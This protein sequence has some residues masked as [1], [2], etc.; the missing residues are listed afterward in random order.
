MTSQ[1]TA[2]HAMEIANGSALE[3]VSAPLIAP[4]KST[5]TQH[6]QRRAS[7]SPSPAPSTA[8]HAIQ[9]LA[10]PGAA[11][12][13]PFSMHLEVQREAGAASSERIHEAAGRGMATPTT[14]MPYA[15]AIAASFG[16]GHDLSGLQAHVGGDASTACRDMNALAFASGNHV[17]FAGAPSLHTAAHEAAHVIQQR[18]GV[19]LK[20]GVGEVGDFYERNADEVADRVVAGLPA[21]DLL[22]APTSSGGGGVQHQAIQRYT[23]VSDL[24][25]D[26]VSDDGKLAVIDHGLVGWAEDSMIAAANAA[27]TAN[28]SKI[29]VEALG[30]GDADVAPPN[31]T[32]GAST[33]RLKQFHM[34]D[35]TTSD[36]LVLPDDC[37]GATQ[38]AL[39]SEHHGRESFVAAHKQGTTE[40]YT[41]EE[42]YHADDLRSGGD[43]STTEVLSG[44]IYVR[45][46]EQEFKKKL[47][48]IDALAEWKK[49]P[50]PKKDELSLKY[51]INDHAVPRMGQ[52]VTIGSERD[53]PDASNDKYN[54]HFAFNLMASGGDYITLEDYDRS[55]KKY[56][57][58]MYGPPSK[59]QSF[60][61]NPDNWSAVDDNHT[62]MVVQHADSLRGTITTAATQ[63]V[64]DPVTFSNS[65][66]LDSGDKVTMQRK[67]QS[68]TKVSVTS[69]KQ[70][71]QVG[72]IMNQFFKLS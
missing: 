39:G 9:L 61:Q 65:R 26:R 43:L 17:V 56:Y 63:L 8:E 49:L 48:R 58:D 1:Q 3:P 21:H 71:G 68:W 46:F 41:G 16:P 29:K 34:V 69:G 40:A 44:Q 2:R 27:L 4:G 22:P 33:T 20:S 55:G 57:L 32:G 62:A 19:H 5:R 59:S 53:M 25:Y 14:A 67:G 64:D 42:S 7:S 66:V 38:K 31:A 52:S 23:V 36:E 28:H 35:R 10:L 50:I 51:G 12:E 24:P 70:A 18:A 13:D 47:S 11:F 37:G 60:N 15:D 54:F 30:S 6:L 72:W 45:I